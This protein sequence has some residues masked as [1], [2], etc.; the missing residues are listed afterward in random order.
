MIVK[1]KH[2]EK[3]DVVLGFPSIDDYKK[4]DGSYLGALVGR[5]ANRIGNGKFTLNNEIFSL[6]KNNGSNTLHGGIEGFSYKTTAC[7][8]ISFLIFKEFLVNFDNKMIKI[9]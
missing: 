6:E 1:D 3:R 8:S 5:V 9:P 2:G 7:P 4:K